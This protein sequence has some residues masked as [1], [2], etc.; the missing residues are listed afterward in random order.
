MGALCLDEYPVLRNIQNV[1]V[2]GH[3][4]PLLPLPR[5]AETDPDHLVLDDPDSAILR[6]VREMADSPSSHELLAPTLTLLPV[7][8]VTAEAP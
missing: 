1:Q 6:V 5:F 7:A 8:D 4:D 3:R 2:R